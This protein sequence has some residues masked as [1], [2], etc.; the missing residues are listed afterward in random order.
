K[1]VTP[2]G[3]IKLKGSGYNDEQTFSVCP[4]N[5]ASKKGIEKFLIASVLCSEAKLVPTPNKPHQFKLI[6]NPTEGALLIAAKKYGYNIEEVKNNLEIIQLN[7]F[8]SERKKM[9]VLV[10]NN[11]EPAYD[12]NSQYLFIKGAPNIV[13]EQCQ[14]Q[15]KGSQVSPF[16]PHEKESFLKQNDQFA[17]QGYRVLALAYKKIE[18]NP[19]LEEDMVFLGFA[20]N[21]DPPREEVKEAVKN[22]TQAGL[23]ITIITGDYS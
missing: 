22:L 1:I 23:K 4:N 21:Y 12:T 14:M 15:Y 20:V 7:P 8:T 6:G 10:K 3:T 16:S 5:T 18:Q 17:I 11:Q 19:P 2:D 13:L 9:S